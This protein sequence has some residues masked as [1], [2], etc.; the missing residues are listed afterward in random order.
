MI[1]WCSSVIVLVEVIG[2]L[3]D[4]W[5]LLCMLEYVSRVPFLGKQGMYMYWVPPH[6]MKS[7]TCLALPPAS[8]LSLSLSGRCGVGV[9]AGT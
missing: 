1:Q 6:G 5:V 8:A 3:L 4:N 7:S 2:F 9:H